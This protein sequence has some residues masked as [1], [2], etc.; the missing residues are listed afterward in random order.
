VSD[1][2]FV[3]EGERHNGV[4]ALFAAQSEVFRRMLFGSM[5]ESVVGSE[6]VLH[7]VTVSAFKFLRS[8]FYGV[9]EELTASVVVDVL[10]SAQKYLVT[11]LVAQCLSFIRSVESVADWFL[12]L[13]QFEASP[14]ELEAAK[15]L[16]AIVDPERAEDAPYILQF[17]SMEFVR[18]P[19]FERL[20][21]PTVVIIIGSD[22]LAVNEHLIWE[23]VLK[24]TRC[25]A[26]NLE[27]VEPEQDDHRRE[28]IEL[29][30]NE[31]NHDDVDSKEAVAGSPDQKE[32]DSPSVGTDHHH[33]ER[34]L[35]A[36]ERTV[37]GQ[38]AR[39]IRFS[40]M[41]G[42]YFREHIVDQNLL[43]QRDV[44]EIMFCRENG[45]KW[46]TKFNDEPRRKRKLQDTFR[47]KDVTLTLEQVAALC[48]GHTVDFRDCYGLFCSATVIEV[49]AENDR[50]K[51]HY[52]EWGSSYDEWFLF[53]LNNAA[54]SNQQSQSLILSQHQ[55]LHRI[56][57]HG[58]IT[59]RKA[60]SQPFKDKL[61][62]FKRHGYRRADAAESTHELQVKLPMAFW[63][64]NQHFI[65]GHSRFIGQW[66]NAKIIGFKTATK[67]S[68]HIKV[69]LYI[70]GDHYEYWVH[71]DNA[72]EVRPMTQQQL[73]RR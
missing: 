33:K 24:W 17:K 25:N 26:A 49:D 54:T 36:T 2:V 31:P 46:T 61:V 45:S 5:M 42:S 13:Q 52:N 69:G 1:V 68:D 56:A 14:F 18:S 23:S 64:K 38:F 43:P 21:A 4:R 35:S 37:M 27:A 44:I 55:V 20:R 51:L 39:Y 9:D 19:L 3:V 15:Y 6:V 58:A 29:E 70:N 11:P 40:Q 73:P 63:I 28:H 16:K 30:L 50:L 72:D 60:Q 53:K 57:K 59:G 10:F 12:I 22:C 7:D 71:P 48:T 34:R 67:Y 66:L 41:D 65:D 32:S 47:L 8:S 62:D